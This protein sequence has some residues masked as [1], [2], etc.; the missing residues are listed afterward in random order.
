MPPILELKDVSKSYGTTEVLKPV[1]LEIQDGEF[2]TLLGPSGSGKTTI[3][4]I[5]GGFLEPSAGQ[6]LFEGREIGQEPAHRRPF[7]TVFQDYALFPHMSVAENVGFGLRVRGEAKSNWQREAQASLDLVGLSGLGSRK[8]S[9]L[10]GG[11]K[12]RVA[13][14]RALICQPRIVL[15]DE[16][17]AALDA[18]RRRQMQLFLKDIQRRVRT[19]F[20]FVTHD[21]EEAMTISDRI[22][23]MDF[24]AI[25]QIGTPRELYYAPASVFTANF[26]GENNVMPGRVAG[27]GMIYTPLGKMQIKHPFAAS[28]EVAVAIRPEAISLSEGDEARGMPGHGYF[29]CRIHHQGGQ[30]PRRRT[31]AVAF[32]KVHQRPG[33]RSAIHRPDG[34][35]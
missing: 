12:Q 16:P 14:A 19:S 29:L 2:L 17:L 35:A 8:I 28:Q 23:L 4:R 13:L 18:D 7:N 15:L 25:Q 5:I 9:Q 31:P 11:Q 21:Q 22:V 32:G 20:L 34:V 3:L 1:R 6:I 24:G 26:F 27:G 30:P 33:A 10:S